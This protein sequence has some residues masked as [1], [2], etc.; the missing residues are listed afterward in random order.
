M[1]VLQA[2]HSYVDFGDCV[3]G[4]S[5]NKIISIVNNSPCSLHYKLHID[6]TMD[7]PYPEDMTKSDK[8]GR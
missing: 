8:I 3:V 7:G 1:Y 6:Q 5:N 4:S 2:E